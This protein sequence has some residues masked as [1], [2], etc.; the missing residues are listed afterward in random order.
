MRNHKNILNF[1][2]RRLIMKTLL[3]FLFMFTV[4]G[5]RTMAQAPA[6]G[7]DTRQGFFKPG[8]TF[9]KGQKYFSEDN[10]YALVFQE[11]GNLVI[12]KFGRNKNRSNHAVWN[13]GTVGIAMKSCVFQTDGN[14]VMYDFSGKPRWDAFSDDKRKNGAPTIFKKGGASIMV[15]QNDG[16]LVLYMSP[17]PK[18]S[19]VRWASDSFEKN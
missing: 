10:R 16:N 17:Y 6:S 14:L 19:E 3:L 7:I 1:S 18:T 11:D 13:S 15:M 2:Q 9:V 12:Y 4:M 5:I 8:T